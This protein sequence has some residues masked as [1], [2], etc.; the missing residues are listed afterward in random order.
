MLVSDDNSSYGV[1]ATE[2]G[3]EHQLCLAHMRKA[4][5]QRNASILIQA[6]QTSAGRLPHAPV[7]LGALGALV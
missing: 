3:L 6:E 1:A 7:H 5:S 2:L 4:A